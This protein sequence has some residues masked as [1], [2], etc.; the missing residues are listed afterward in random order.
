MPTISDDERKAVFALAAA[1]VRLQEAIPHIKIALRMAQLQVPDGKVGIAVIAKA[2]DGTGMITA[3][4]E[5]DDFIKDV[6]LLC[7]GLPER[8][9]A[10]LAT[11]GPLMTAEEAASVWEW[12]RER[13][14][15]N[16]VEEPREQCGQ[17]G[18]EILGYHACQGVPSGFSED[19]S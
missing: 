4:F 16:E 17:C 14:G 10:G 15:E 9:N 2:P 6:E 5:G 19:E 8:I 11:I 3:S 13:R 7:G 18:A 12:L 1:R